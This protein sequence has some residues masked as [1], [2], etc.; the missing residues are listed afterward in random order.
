MQAPLLFGTRDGSGCL[1]ETGRVSRALVTVTDSFAQYTRVYNTGLGTLAISTTTKLRRTDQVVFQIS[2]SPPPPPF[3]ADKLFGFHRCHLL[4]PP[5]PPFFFFLHSFFFFLL[6]FFDWSSDL[7]TLPPPQKKFFVDLICEY[8][9]HV[10]PSFHLLGPHNPSQILDSCASRQEMKFYLRT[11]LHEKAFTVETRLPLWVFF[12]FNF[13]GSTATV[14]WIWLRIG[15]WLLRPGA[16]MLSTG[17]PQV[18]AKVIILLAI[19]VE[20]NAS[21]MVD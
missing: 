13:K 3:F 16:P 4:P 20:T 15:H 19:S 10:P 5:P 21:I 18:F 6:L 17:V 12:Q 2:L 9:Q 8:T 1:S 11:V 14:V 7:S